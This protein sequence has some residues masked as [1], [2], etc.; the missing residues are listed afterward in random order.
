MRRSAWP[1]SRGARIFTDNAYVNCAII[2]ELPGNIHL[3]GRGRMDAAL[4]ASPNKPRGRGRPPVRGLQ[5]QPD[6]D[7]AS[8]EI[9]IRC[10]A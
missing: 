7:P 4:Y 3:V 10:A 2:R 5:R 9:V 6:R 1:R 8:G